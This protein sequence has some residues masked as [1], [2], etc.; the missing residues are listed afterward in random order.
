MT[1][2]RFRSGL[3][4]CIATAILLSWISGCTNSGGL[5]VIQL[6]WSKSMVIQEMGGSRGTKQEVIEGKGAQLAWEVWYYPEGKVFFY[7]SNVKEVWKYDEKGT[8]KLI[9]PQNENQSDSEKKYQEFHYV[10]KSD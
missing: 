10:P 5:D 4:A 7:G 9:E 6:N 8:L 3:M 2:R 1:M